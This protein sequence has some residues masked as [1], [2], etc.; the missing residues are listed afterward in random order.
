M[1]SAF[2]AERTSL[3]VTLIRKASTRLNCRNRK[4]CHSDVHQAA[5][6]FG[7]LPE[8]PQEHEQVPAG[9]A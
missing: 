9:S 2:G 5:Q 7:E 8:P 3:G 1:V 4:S 6:A